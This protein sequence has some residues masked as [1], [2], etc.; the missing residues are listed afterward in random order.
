MA[1]GRIAAGEGELGARGERE[2]R[3]GIILGGRPRRGLWPDCFALR[4]KETARHPELAGL[5]GRQEPP[6]VVFHRA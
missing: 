5:I 1:E 2:D 3:E 6:L 4:S